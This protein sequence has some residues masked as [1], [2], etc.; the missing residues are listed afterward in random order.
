MSLKADGPQ[1]YTSKDNE[2]GKYVLT[3][4]VDSFGDEVLSLLSD[5]K[6]TSS[7]TDVATITEAGELTVV[8][9]GSTTVTATVT[10][11]TAVSKIQFR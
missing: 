1:A 3:S 11:G 8:G 9:S 7:N 6:W 2:K 10:N 4:A 5:V